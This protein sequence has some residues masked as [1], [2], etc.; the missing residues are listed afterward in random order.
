ML[1]QGYGNFKGV[2][3]V[4][5][6]KHL[7]ALYVHCNVHSLN[8]ALANS[9]NIH[10]IHNCIG[11]IKSVGNFINILARQT[12]LLKNKIKEFIPE[13]KWTKL[14]SL[15]ETRWVENHNGMIRFFDIYKL[16]KTCESI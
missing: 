13:T 7:A 6:E 3:S 9:S 15:C 10:Y 12:E 14:T 1:G 8:L 4:I 2:Q 5:R 11:T 16:L